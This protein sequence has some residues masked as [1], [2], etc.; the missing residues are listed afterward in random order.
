MFNRLTDVPKFYPFDRWSSALA[1]LHG[2]S[3]DRKTDGPLR[4]IFGR[5]TDG[6]YSTQ[7]PQPRAMEMNRGGFTKT[8]V[9]IDRR[10]FSTVILPRGSCLTVMI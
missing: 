1:M 6:T 8:V 7:A 3:F 2:F 5:L 4:V 9:P 10:R